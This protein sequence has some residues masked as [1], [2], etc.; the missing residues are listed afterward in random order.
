MT[1]RNFQYL[2]IDTLEDY[3]ATLE[4]YVSEGPIDKKEIENKEL[5]GNAGYEKFI[6]GGVTSGKTKEI[7][8]TFAVTSAAKFQKLYEILEKQ[9]E[10]K[11]LD[12][13]DKETW[14]QICRGDLLEIEAKLRLP[15]SFAMVQV[16]DGI[17]P[18]VDIL[19]QMGELPFKDAKTKEAFEGIKSVTKLS[20]DKPIPIIYEPLSTPGYLF[21]ANLQ[22]KFLKCQISEIEGDA[23]VFG[24][25][26]RIVRKGEKAEVFSLLPAISGMGPSMSNEK[27][28]EMQNSLVNQELADIVKG[29]ALVMSVLAIYR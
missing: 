22:R 11:F 28:K 2:D 24:K 20:E 18:W 29:P 5:S 17:S 4:G 23:T 12:L 14:N 26:H 19:K 25:V 1:L 16:M 6:E 9:E 27:K 15:K 7:K 13:F 10:F 8:Q 21:T 3:L